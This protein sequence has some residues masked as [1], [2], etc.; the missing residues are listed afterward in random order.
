MTIN[1]VLEVV[2]DPENSHKFIVAELSDG[3]GGKRLVVR[4]PKYVRY[5][6]HADILEFLQ[7]EVGS[8]GLKARCIGGGVISI[9]TEKKTIKIWDDSGE[10]G[11]EPDRQETI[12]MLQVAFPEFSVTSF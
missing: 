6:L 1:E 8:S 10:F 9:N 2:V 11:E 5:E 7:K 4:A 12:R 3:N